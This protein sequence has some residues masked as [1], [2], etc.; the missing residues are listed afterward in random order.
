MN[1]NFQK[2]ECMSKRNGH[3]AFEQSAKRL[4]CKVANLRIDEGFH[5][6]RH[7]ALND[8][9]MDNSYSRVNSELRRLHYDN[10]LRHGTPRTPRLGVMTNSMGPM[11]PMTH[12]G[13]AEP[14]SSSSQPP[15]C[16]DQTQF[17][18]ADVVRCVHNQ[19]SRCLECMGRKTHQVP[20]SAYHA[21]ESIF[22]G[23]PSATQCDLAESQA[24]GV[25][26]RA[27]VSGEIYF[28]AFA[29]L[30]GD[31]GL[32]RQE[33]C[34]LDLGSGR[35]KA[36]VAVALLFPQARAC[37]VEIRPQ[38]HQAAEALAMD[39][40]LRSRI[41]FVK[42]NFFDVQWN[43]ADVI[44]VNATG[45][46]DVL[47]RRLEKKLDAEAK[48]G[49]RIIALSVPLRASRLKGLGPPLRYRMSWGNASIYT[50]M[51]ETDVVDELL[52]RDDSLDS[53]AVDRKT[54]S[55]SH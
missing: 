12:L 23:A 42:A 22:F 8:M 32:E 36:I 51:V 45:F 37:G 39:S 43:E 41:R 15:Q 25:P 4:C 10:N 18:L 7:D 38:L 50:Y 55:M 11:G 5:D 52:G 19:R 31:L 48:K 1:L 14:S 6:M 30:L 33:F 13:P 47:L 2:N 16:N 9:A 34:F 3:F 46:E 27:L 17:T 53:G 49:T 35:G 40:Q 44:L 20:Q 54:D 21:F 26:L 29:N 24:H 28:P